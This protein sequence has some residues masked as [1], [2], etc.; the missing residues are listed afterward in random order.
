M[1]MV[2]DE[3]LEEVAE[4]LWLEVYEAEFRGKSRGRFAI[5]REQLK[6]ALGTEKLHETTVFRLQAAALH[7]GLVIID[8]DDIFP[9]V[10]VD[11]LRKYRRPPKAVFEEIFPGPDSDGDGE[12]DELSDDE[13]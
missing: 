11:V 2:T 3:R 6:K 4:L 8:L 1:A 10:E 12:D 5:T 9:C 7:H 13:E